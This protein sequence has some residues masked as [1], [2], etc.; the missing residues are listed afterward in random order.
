MED[1]KKVKKVNFYIE[2]Y[3]LL[4][5]DRIYG[6]REVEL[7]S[8]FKVQVL[9]FRGVNWLNPTLCTL[10][11]IPTSLKLVTHAMRPRIARTEV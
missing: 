3:I 8:V 4:C 7:M 11:L 1:R 10:R 2:S 9:G 5:F 6:I